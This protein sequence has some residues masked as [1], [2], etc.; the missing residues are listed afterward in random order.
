[1][2][3]R[4]IEQAEA[5]RE[6]DEREQET[7]VY[8]SS[9]SEAKC[10]ICMVGP[11]EFRLEPCGHDQFCAECAA[12]LQRIG[13]D[14][15]PVCRQ[16]LGTAAQDPTSGAEAVQ[17]RRPQSCAA[18]LC[19]CIRDVGHGVCCLTFGC[20]GI[21]AAIAP[22]LQLL[23][24][25][26]FIWYEWHSCPINALSLEDEIEQY[27]WWLAGASSNMYFHFLVTSVSAGLVGRAVFCSSMWFDLRFGWR[28]RRFVR[29]VSQEV[30]H[31]RLLVTVFFL[32]S[33]LVT[34]SRTIVFDGHFFNAP[35]AYRPYRTP[36]ECQTSVQEN[37]TSW[38][39][40]DGA[41]Y[42][43]DNST[44][45][46]ATFYV[47]TAATDFH[48]SCSTFSTD[49]AV[50]ELWDCKARLGPGLCAI[51]DPW[52]VPPCHRL[53]WVLGLKFGLLQGLAACINVLTDLWAMR[54]VANNPGDRLAQG[55]LCD[56]RFVIV[57]MPCLLLFQLGLLL[58]STHFYHGSCLQVTNPLGVRLHMVQDGVMALGALLRQWLESIFIIA[59]VAIYLIMIA[60]CIALLVLLLS[61]VVWAAE[62][63]A[64]TVFTCA[65]TNEGPV[66]RSCSSWLGKLT[67]CAGKGFTCL[68][69]SLVYFW[70]CCGAAIVL[71]G[72]L[73]GCE[74]FLTILL[75]GLVAAETK[76]ALHGL[77]LT[78][79]ICIKLLAVATVLL[80]KASLAEFSATDSVLPSAEQ[81][82]ASTIGH[83]SIEHV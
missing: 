78:F 74:C 64:L 31:R 4:E 17:P 69:L 46:E 67:Q 32:V 7:P 38:Y 19:S 14:R 70:A 10:L 33:T 23:L 50:L 57:C 8:S 39:G 12:N 79:D 47:A 45:T 52:G 72:S 9:A 63:C 24:H 68:R 16:K 28:R 44:V 30:K 73:I 2:D 62:S 61:G 37:G 43:V 18:Q 36:L 83:L 82:P 20:I 81:V 55:L 66:S 54:V 41:L 42:C 76:S 5:D 13:I 49:S 6:Q 60:A 71:L 80:P 1:M 26:K 56:G 3:G 22:L 75:R 77:V 35:R 11:R 25:M 15:C 51:V 29:S 59:A 53:G 40:P 65:L 48:S 34:V 27:S 58:P 21:C